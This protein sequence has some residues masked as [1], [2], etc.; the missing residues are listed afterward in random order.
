MRR[1][2]NR[3]LEPRSRFSI[4][5][6]CDCLPV[7]RRTHII[8]AT[9]QTTRPWCLRL[10]PGGPP[11]YTRRNGNTFAVSNE[12]EVTQTTG[13][14]SRARPPPSARSRS[15]SRSCSRERRRER[16]RFYEGRPPPRQ[17]QQ[18]YWPPQQQARGAVEARS[19]TL[20]LEGSYRYPKRLPLCPYSHAVR[21]S[22]SCCLTSTLD[23]QTPDA[24]QVCL[25]VCLH[26][27]HL[28]L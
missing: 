25:Q 27:S 14:R 3:G 7:A 22:R 5:P 28:A 13:E 18:P 2:P 9:Q 11:V 19:T 23:C 17:Q 12:P 20:Y 1:L 15:R 21:T 8:A 24:T 4:S 16:D 10:D 6:S 26:L